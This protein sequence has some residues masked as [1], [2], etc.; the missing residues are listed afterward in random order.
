[1]KS[2]LPH[3]DLHFSD[4]LNFLLCSA[5]FFSPSLWYS[6][7]RI[8]TTCSPPSPPST[9]WP[10]SPSPAG[11]RRPS[12]A[13][14]CSGRRAW[15]TTRWTSPLTWG[16]TTTRGCAT[17]PCAPSR[18]LAGRTTDSRRPRVITSNGRP[19]NSFPVELFE[20]TGNR[21]N[22]ATARIRVHCNSGRK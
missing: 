7:S 14:S 4:K 11:Q 9:S 3:L 19:R 16:S 12:R 22:M 10:P 20:N 1:M 5:V 17:A 8:P 18:S 21:A 13:S 6:S 2:L 15:T